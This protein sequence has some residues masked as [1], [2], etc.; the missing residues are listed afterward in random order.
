MDIQ[1]G[2]YG[3]YIRVTTEEIADD[4]YSVAEAKE[5]LVNLEDAVDELKHYIALVERKN[6]E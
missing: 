5:L 3:D 4:W 2:R 1:I 6:I